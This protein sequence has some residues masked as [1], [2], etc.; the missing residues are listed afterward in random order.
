[1]QRQAAMVAKSFKSIFVPQKTKPLAV[2]GAGLTPDLDKDEDNTKKLLDNRKRLYEQ[3]HQWLKRAELEAITNPTLKA[4]KQIEQEYQARSMTIFK[5]VGKGITF[6]EAERMW[7]ELAA[8]T[9][10]AKRRLAETV[11]AGMPMLRRVGE[12]RPEV[13]ARGKKIAA[14]KEHDEQLAIL[15]KFREEDLISQQQ[16]HDQK[17]ALDMAYAEKRGMIEKELQEQ[18]MAAQ[19]QTQTSTLERIEGGIQLAGEAFGHISDTYNMYQDMQMAKMNERYNRERRAIEATP[20]WAHQRNAKL[21]KLDEKREQEEKRMNKNK[22]KMAFVQSI[23]QGA[24]AVTNALSSSPPPINFIMA[25]LVGAA[26]AAQSAM[27][28]SQA[29]AKGGIV[30]GVGGTDSQI[31]RATPGEMVLTPEQQANLFAIAQGRGGGSVG[32]I[33]MSINI[34]GNVNEDILDEV[35]NIQQANL[36]KLRE[37]LEELNYQ[38]ELSFLKAV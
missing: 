11:I 37:Q 19:E 35:S 10:A 18:L 32:N 4:L 30:S 5:A 13:E 23:I 21:A 16:Y 6:A 29:F 26:A 31:V 14:R 36:I 38:N 22:Q 27:I 15:N 3:F 34:E 8:I 24:L 7:S 25:G 2:T 9:E 1:M 12:T 33:D 20:M 17:L 28:A